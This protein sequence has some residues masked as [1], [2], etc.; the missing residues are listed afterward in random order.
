MDV[1][2]RYAGAARDELLGPARV[3]T[4]VLG[5]DPDV[6]TMQEANLTIFCHDA[7]FAYHDKDVR[8]FAAFPLYILEDVELRVWLV[9]PWGNCGN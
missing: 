1:V 9:G 4:E 3:A 6:M 8:T 7:L 5:P 2:Q